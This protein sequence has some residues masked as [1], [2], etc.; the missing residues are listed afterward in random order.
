MN[1]I[2]EI[3]VYIF[4]GN[5]FN[6]RPR[7]IIKRGKSLEEEL[8]NYCIIKTR[9]IPKKLKFRIVARHPHGG[10]RTGF[11]S[12]NEKIATIESSDFSEE[13]LLDYA[14]KYAKNYAELHRYNYVGLVETQNL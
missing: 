14:K 11:P 10:G 12:Y 8:D 2:E 4:K 3:N 6:K 7:Y 9:K 13:L 5:R 1:E